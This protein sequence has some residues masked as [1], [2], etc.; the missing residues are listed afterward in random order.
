[1]FKF[2]FVVVTCSSI[3]S[4]GKLLSSENIVERVFKTCSHFFKGSSRIIS[5]PRQKNIRENLLL[6]GS[7]KILI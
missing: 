1:M 4:G 6:T 7:S 2:G 5:Q 3:Y